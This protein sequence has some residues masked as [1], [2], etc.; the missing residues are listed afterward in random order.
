[1]KK[2]ALIENVL[3]IVRAEAAFKKGEKHYVY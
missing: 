1:M 2:R 3:E